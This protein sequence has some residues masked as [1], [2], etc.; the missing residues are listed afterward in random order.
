[1]TVRIQ[2]EAT[3]T[4]DDVD[5]ETLDRLLSALAP[6]NAYLIVERSDIDEGYAQT[7]M[8]TGEQETKGKYVVEYRSGPNQHY[9]AFTDDRDLVHRVLSG[10]AFDHPDWKSALDFSVLDLGF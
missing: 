9:Q 2:T 4:F 5:E 7:A 6:G 1:M 3:G 8:N 10:W